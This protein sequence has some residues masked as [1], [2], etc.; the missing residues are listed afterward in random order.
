V[1]TVISC[2]VSAALL[3]AMPGL[4]QESLCNPCVDPPVRKIQPDFTSPNQTVTVTAEDM[5]NLGVIT[6][7]DMVNQLTAA[8]EN[9]A[10]AAA[11]AAAA[12]AS[13][14]EASPNAEPHPASSLDESAE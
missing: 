2:W 10:A 8:A 14:A 4:A 12:D 3:I 5:R 13:D 9:E 6:V 11:A 1:K 7:A